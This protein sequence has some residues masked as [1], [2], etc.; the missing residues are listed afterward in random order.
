M[1]AYYSVFLFA[2]FFLQ[3]AAAESDYS[4]GVSWYNKEALPD[5]C[6]A[7]DIDKVN[8]I[9]ALAIN[10]QLKAS[11]F[12]EVSNWTPK[13]WVTGTGQGRKLPSCAGICLA[14]CDKDGPQYHRYLCLAYCGGISCRLRRRHLMDRLL[15]TIEVKSLEEAL[16]EKC[17][18]AIHLES[19][20]EGEYSSNCKHALAGA[21]CNVMISA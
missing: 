20:R 13:P 11:G 8:Q 18:G 2:S 9:T 10:Q 4:Y 3:L 15:T 16:E 17:K 7:E 19:Q 12:E 6:S 14:Y 21:S 1:F 5:A